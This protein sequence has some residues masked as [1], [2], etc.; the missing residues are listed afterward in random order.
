MDFDQAFDARLFDK[1]HLDLY[2]KAKPLVWRFSFDFWGIQRDIERVCDLF[3][4]EGMMNRHK[5][6]IFAL[7]GFGEG[8]EKDIARVKRIAELGAYPFVMRY[9]P[10]D[11]LDKRPPAKGWDDASQI[12][13]FTRFYNQPKIW[14][15]ANAHDDLERWLKRIKPEH[16]MNKQQLSLIER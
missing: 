1:W 7:V 6:T 4:N 2:K 5:V 15:S 13:Q 10:L 14:T 12:T 9:V 16:A 8:M 3:Q 11:S